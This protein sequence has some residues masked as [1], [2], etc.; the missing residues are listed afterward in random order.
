M[1]ILFIGGTGVISTACS[2]LCIEKGVDLYLLNRGESFRKPPA[3][4]NI[5]KADIR[6]FE[7]CESVLAR[8]KFDVVVDWIAYKEEHVKNDYEL[9]HGKTSQYIF[10]GSASA[11]QKPPAKSPITEDVPLHNPFWKYSQQK[12]DCENFLMEKFIEN[13]FP[14]TICRPS[15]TYDNTKIALYGGYTTLNRMKIGKP[16]IL[17]EDGN[18][19]WTLTNAKDFA[20]GFIGLFGKPQTIGQAYHITSD[21]ALTWNQIAKIFADEIRAELKTVYMP[22]QFIAKHDA[23]WGYNLIGDKGYNTVFDNSKIKNLVPD[24]EAT[25]PFA[26]GVKEIIDW[27]SN[28]ENQTVN[29]ELDALMDKMIQDYNKTFEK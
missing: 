22:S 26:E 29:Y 27:Y 13:K 4:L 20:K 23:E 18:T 1:K 6:N 24:F 10:I 28:P 8:E 12:I 19:L 14:A 11:Y 7:Q 16:I 3:G 21:E 9:F 15:H 2:Q 25:I 17:H 5:I